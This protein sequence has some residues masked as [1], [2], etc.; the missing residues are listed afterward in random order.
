MNLIE[1]KQNE[2][3]LLIKKLQKDRSYRFETGL[4]WI[5]GIH[6]VREAIRSNCKFH[7]FYLKDKAYENIESETLIKELITLSALANKVSEKIERE[8]FETQSPQGIGAII[9]KPIFSKLTEDEPILIIDEIQDPGNLGT[10]IRSAEA[11]GIENIILLKGTVDVWGGKVLRS[12]MGSIFRMKILEGCS[13]DIVDTLQSNGYQLIGTTL[14]KASSYK[15]L[16]VMA[17]SALILGNE[18]RGIR[19]E[20]LEKLDTKTYIP[21]SGLVESLNVGV[22]G[23]ILMLHFYGKDC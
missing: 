14:Q 12:T 22:A 6:L 4:I 1:S 9:Y 7:S 2:K 13:I 16:K 5:E 18:G 23:S 11:A 20:I 3:I 10:L 19:S 15:E 21:M 17:K 8:I